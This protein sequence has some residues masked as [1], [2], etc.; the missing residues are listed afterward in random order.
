DGAE[1]AWAIE[2]PLTSPPEGGPARYSGVWVADADGANAREVLSN[3]DRP[4]VG[5]VRLFGWSEHGMILLF[6]PGFSASIPNDGLPIG[7]LPAAANEPR[8]VDGLVVIAHEE[9]L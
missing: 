2:A 7:L 5:Q 6:N 3:R 1:L 9:L 4:E 8:R